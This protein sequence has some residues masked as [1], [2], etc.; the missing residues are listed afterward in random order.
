MIEV[1]DKTVVLFSDIACPWSHVA[2]YRFHETR[3]RLGLHGAVR[4]DPRAFPLEVFNSRPTPKRIL[5][6]EIPVAGELAPDAGWKMWDRQPHDYPVT[7]LLALEAVYAAKAQSSSA[8]EALD[9][10]LRRGFFGAGRNVSMRHEILDIAK[11]C[12]GVDEVR[13]AG[14]LDS[15][16]YRRLVFDDYEMA[17]TS[18]VRG[19]PHF[20]L[21]DGG[22]FHNPGIELHWEG[23][24]GE[25]FPVVEKD[26]PSV[27]EDMLKRAA[28]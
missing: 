16:T 20:F 2:L 21:S 7:T 13:L 25:G 4:L 12:K 24:K 1:P 17:G 26:D 23:D 8:A 11:D 14:D 27:F 18:S 10:D 5:D 22:D 6:A 28:D 15:G 9:R 3:E 19:S